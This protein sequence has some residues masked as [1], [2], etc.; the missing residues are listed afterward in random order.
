M[1]SSDSLPLHNAL[2]E[3]LVTNEEVM[4]YQDAARVLGGAPPPH[5]TYAVRN[6]VSRI[7]NVGPWRSIGIL[8]VRLDALLMDDRTGQPSPSHFSAH[9]SYSVQTWMSVF[10]DWSICRHTNP[11]G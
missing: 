1:S 7:A 5:R 3:H 2:F 9:H 4:L 11:I 10:G 8:T 6:Q